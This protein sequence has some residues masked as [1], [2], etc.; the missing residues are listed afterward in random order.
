MIFGDTI[1]ILRPSVVRDRYNNEVLDWEN[2]TS[3]PV[4][5]LV[6]V[7]PAGSTEGAGGRAVAQ[8][9]S[10]RLFTPAGVDLD[11][12]PTDRV[13]HRGR[14]LEVVGEIERWPHPIIPGAV[15]H[16]EANLQ[17]ASD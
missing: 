10:W 12:L 4:E 3:I 9:S 16:I 2:A 15:H 1:S 11:L 17:K 14:Y 7:Q 13:F 8:V 5:R 6:S